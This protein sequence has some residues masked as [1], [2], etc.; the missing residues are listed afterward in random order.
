MWPTVSVMGN[1]LRWGIYAAAT[2]LAS[3]VLAHTVIFLAHGWAGYGQ[4]LTSPGHGL[5]W[6]TAVVI[7]LTLGG[8]LLVAACWRLHS[9]VQEARRLELPRRASEPDRRAMARRWL[10]WWLALAVVTALLFAL[11][12]NVELASIGQRL[13]GI[14][15]LLSDQYP[16]AMGII[17]LV[18][19]AVSFVAALF[20]WRLEALVVR[21]DALQAA[22]PAP[23]LSIPRTG[24]P[25]DRRPASILGRRLAG[26]APPPL[27]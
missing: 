19:L 11:E 14:G 5:G 4:P 16:Y 2:A 26:R 20:G 24:D 23:N 10:A 12:E 15:I 9:L 25:A 21:L 3:F 7:S 18:A 1:R 13:P 17:T 6:M 8:S 27:V 22:H